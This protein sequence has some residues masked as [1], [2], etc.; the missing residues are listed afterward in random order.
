MKIIK[1]FKIFKMKIFKTFFYY[2]SANL[3]IYPFISH[4]NEIYSE[5]IFKIAHISIRV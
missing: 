5:F 1:I 4:L 3:G 2:M